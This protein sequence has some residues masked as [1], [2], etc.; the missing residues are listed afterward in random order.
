MNGMF[1]MLFFW[2]LATSLLV[3]LTVFMVT[4]SQKR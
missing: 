1:V 4:Q 2:M 3:T